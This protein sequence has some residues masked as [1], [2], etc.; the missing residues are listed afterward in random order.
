MNETCKFCNQT[1]TSQNS[2]KIHLR[3]AKFCREYRNITFGCQKCTYHT[4]SILDID[5]HITTC[6]GDSPSLPQTT[7]CE[8]SSADIFSMESSRIR[9]L[10]ILLA[11]ERA[12][13][14]IWMTLLETNTKIKVPDIVHVDGN[15][16]NF[17]PMRGM[18]IDVIV[19]KY[20]SSTQVTHKIVPTTDE[21]VMEQIQLDTT[22]KQSYRTAKGSLELVPEREPI[23]N[24]PMVVVLEEDTLQS[25]TEYFD[26]LFE[27]LRQT[28]TY[29]KILEN[30]RNKRLQLL[31]SMSLEDYISLVTNHV[32]RLRAIFHTKGYSDKKIHTITSKGLSSLEARLIT[33]TAHIESHIDM[34]ELSTLMGVLHKKADCNTMYIPYLESTLCKRFHNYGIVVFPLGKLLDNFLFNKYDFHNIIY[35]PLAKSSDDDPYSYYVLENISKDNKR[36]WRM[37]CRLDELVTSLTSNLLPYMVGM[38]RILY[39]LVFNDNEFRADYMSRCQLTD[40][41]CEQLLINI[42]IIS[43]THDFRKLLKQKIRLRATLQPTINDKFN[44]YGDD[45]L[46]RKRLQDREDADAVDVLKQLFDGIS[47]EDMVDFYRSRSI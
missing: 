47:T 30:I 27:K 29:T 3:T 34:D 46:Q 35:L 20:F 38:F 1:Y 13:S 12:K 31:K 4:L 26:S 19:H 32:Q 37:D 25:N 43:K 6:T 5:K 23:V 39:K 18:D 24:T 7:L 42:L 16:V 17:L 10:E 28:R 15:T 40:G 8:T 2:L 22:K 33:S 14:E 11:V 41:D 44:L 9:E 36:N 21:L 45:P